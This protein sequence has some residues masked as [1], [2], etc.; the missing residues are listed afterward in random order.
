M[1]NTALHLAAGAGLVGVCR[2][3]LASGASC[4]VINNLRNRPIDLATPPVSKVLE[5]EQPVRGDSDVESE[6]LEAAKNGDLPA[7]KVGE[8]ELGFRTSSFLSPLLLPP[9]FLSLPFSPLPSSISA[10][11]RTS[12]AVTPRAGT[13]PPSTLLLGS[14]EFRQWSTCCR[15]VLMSTPGTRGM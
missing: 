12:T 11:L 3:L 8:N 13:P 4:S 2:L 7:L 10:P 1:G 14:T 5:E 6:L 9:F 15:M